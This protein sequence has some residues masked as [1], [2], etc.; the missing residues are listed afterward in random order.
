MR[1]ANANKKAKKAAIRTLQ[2]LEKN[3]RELERIQRDPSY[4][5]KIK[6]RKRR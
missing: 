5:P 1:K 3:K 6:R 2:R 4:K